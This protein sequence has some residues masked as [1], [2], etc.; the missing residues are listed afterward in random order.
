MYPAGHHVAAWRHPDTAA[1]A[2]T[3]L[4][5]RIAF[6]KAAERAK[7]DLIF[8]ADGVAAHTNDLK[9]LSRTDEWAVGFEPLTLLSALAVVT[10]RIGL[11]ATASTTFN[12]P[13]NLARKF[14][15]LDQI[16]AGRAGW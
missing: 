15:S 6:A 2:T 3:S 8:L 13:F 4:R 14:A 10:E 9:S 12:E 7:F 16:S 11:V 5:Q 1:D